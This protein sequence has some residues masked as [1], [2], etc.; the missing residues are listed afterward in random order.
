MDCLWIIRRWYERGTDAALVRRERE[1]L[2]GTGD[3]VSG[4]RKRYGPLPCH[5]LV[6]AIVSRHLC[7]D[8]PI[9]GNLLTVTS[10]RTS[11][12]RL[13]QAA[14]SYLDI[15]KVRTKLDTKILPLHA[16]SS[17]QCLSIIIVFISSCLVVS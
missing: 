6:R 10:S 16:V 4:K 14:S 2:Q 3:A 5:L 7:S 17:L 13:L 8:V 9:P 1:G 12:S 11:L 15:H